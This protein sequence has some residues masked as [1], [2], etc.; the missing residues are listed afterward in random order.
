MEI[1]YLA[2]NKNRVF[3]LYALVTQYIFLIL[4]L[5]VGGYLLGRYAIFQTI[6]SGGII[7]TIGAISGIIIFIMELLKIGKTY[8]E[9]YKNI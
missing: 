5:T 1:V 8:N 7:A 4:V 6:L 2:Q 3:K 9:W